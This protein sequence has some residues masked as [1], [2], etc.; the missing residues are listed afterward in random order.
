MGQ[1]CNSPPS[2]AGNR[3]GRGRPC[4]ELCCSGEV[5][6]LWRRG[7]EEL[8]EGLCSWLPYIR[9]KVFSI[10]WWAVFVPS[11]AS[12]SRTAQ[13]QHGFP[14]ETSVLTLYPFKEL[15]RRWELL[16]SQSK[17]Q[18]TRAILLQCNSSSSSVCT[19]RAANH[20]VQK[21]GCCSLN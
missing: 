4:S 20:P 21:E 8:Q 13:T 1:W 9:G 6:F 12:C 2:V 5:Q 3:N 19:A 14:S 11:K 15:R 10:S 7:S 17:V 16:L 18:M